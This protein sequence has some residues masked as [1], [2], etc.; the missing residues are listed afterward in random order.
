MTP[1]LGVDTS[2]LPPFAQLRILRP[3]KDE[4]AL[5][6]KFEQFDAE[7]KGYLGQTEFTALVRRLGLNLTD[8][9]AASAFLSLDVT[10]EGRVEFDALSKWWFKY[11]RP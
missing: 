1:G 6:A 5:R 4:A 11:D 10:G 7:D 3:M 8:A 9:K 2:G